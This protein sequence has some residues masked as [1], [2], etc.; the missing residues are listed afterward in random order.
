[1][2]RKTYQGKRGINPALARM[3]ERQKDNFLISSAYKAHLILGL[4]VLHDKFG[5]GQK[6][7][8]RYID[9]LVALLDSYNRGYISVKDLEQVLQDEVH[10]KITT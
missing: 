10:L 5:F 8:E 3:N 9:E 2:S 4:T 6:R 1:M 7:C